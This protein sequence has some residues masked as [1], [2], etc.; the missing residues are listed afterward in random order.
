MIKLLRVMHGNGGR[1]DLSPDAQAI[2]DYAVKDK[3]WSEGA[4]KLGFVKE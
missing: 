4:K 2:L 1:E 3:G